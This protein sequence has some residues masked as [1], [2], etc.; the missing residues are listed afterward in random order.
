MISWA[1]TFSVQKLY[2]FWTGRVW[3]RHVHIYTYAYI[4]ITWLDF[5]YLETG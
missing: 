4:T 1:F 2:Y 3:D 5:V